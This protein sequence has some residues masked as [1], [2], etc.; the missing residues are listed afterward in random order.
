MKA[1]GTRLRHNNCAGKNPS[2]RLGPSSCN[3]LK[4]ALIREEI[5]IFFIFTSE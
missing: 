4:N 5:A 1:L 2:L 3:F